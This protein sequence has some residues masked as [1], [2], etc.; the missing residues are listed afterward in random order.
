M[1]LISAVTFL[2]GILLGSV[3]AYAVPF[4]TIDGVTVVFGTGNSIPTIVYGDVRVSGYQGRTPRLVITDGANSDVMK[5]T[6]IVFT[7]VTDPGVGGES[8]FIHFRNTFGTIATGANPQNYQV[9]LSGLFGGS[10]TA[11]NSV[12]LEGEVS[13]SGGSYGSTIGTVSQTVPGTLVGPTAPRRAGPVSI[14]CGTVPCADTLIGNLDLFMR[15]NH[16]FSM[17]GSAGVGECD[18]IGVDGEALCHEEFE[19]ERLSWLE[20]Q[21]EVPE[22]ASLLLVFSG[23][24]VFFLLGKKYRLFK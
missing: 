24:G 2:A 23:L 21:Q 12:S 22:P 20:L 15:L 14:N 4:M 19:V 18:T 13:F 9:L 11:G 1:K 16:T 5:L 10:S 7:L 3:T 6:D 8:V 17:S